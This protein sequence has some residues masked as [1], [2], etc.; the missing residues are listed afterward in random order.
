MKSK[1]GF[2]SIVLRA[3]LD[4][5]KGGIAAIA[6]TIGMV[7]GSMIAK[8]VGFPMPAP[9]AYVDS[10]RLLPLMLLCNIPLAIVL[11]ECYRKLPFKYWQRVAALF[12]S[13]YILYSL[14]NMLDAFLYSPMPN[15]AT[16]LFIYLFPALLTSFIVAFLWRSATTGLPAIGWRN[17]LANGNLWRFAAAWLCYVPIYYLIGLLVVPFTKSYYTDPS[18]SLGLVL[19]QLWAILLMQIP[20]G[21]L[22]LLAVLPL[23]RYWPGSRVALWLWTGSIIFIQVANAA[24]FQSYWLPPI[25]RIPH[26]L[27]LLTDSFLQAALYVLLLVPAN[28]AARKPAAFRQLQTHLQNNRGRNEHNPIS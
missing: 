27:E 25:V 23:L 15:L 3:V 4:L 18:H 2:G 8:V 14:V 28:Q 13:N 11:G 1:K 9:P 12:L 20:R 5:L 16:N 21:L 26:G 19:P 7:L 10:T 17:L 24:I 6:G 22:F